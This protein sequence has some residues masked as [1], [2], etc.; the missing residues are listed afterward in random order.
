MLRLKFLF[1]QALYR[2][3]TSETVNALIRANDECCAQGELEV[4]E[5]ARMKTMPRHPASATASLLALR[6]ALPKYEDCGLARFAQLREA[7]LASIKAEHW[8][9]G[10]R[11]P[12]ESAL[13]A[14]TPFSLGT[15]QRALRALVEAGVVTRQQGSGSYV[16]YAHHRIDD[17]SLC[18]F[19][20]DDGETLLPVFSRVLSRR[21]WPH[22]GTWS[23]HFPGRHA[24]LVRLERILDVNG[25]FNIYSRFYFDGERFKSLASRPFAELAGANFKELLRKEFNVPVTSSRQSLQLVVIPLAIGRHIGVAEQGIGAA[26]EIVGRGSGNDTVYFQQMFIPPSP[27]RLLTQ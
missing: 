23:A 16:A 19:L 26:L 9:A 10:E 2:L 21:L 8:K 12:T 6:R 27:R 1:C 3:E 17:V 22:A 7:L 13:V 5:R 14:A 15:V 24:V 11:L 18:R 25:E 4:E 20:G